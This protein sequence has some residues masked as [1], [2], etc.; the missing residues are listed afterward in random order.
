MNGSPHRFQENAIPWSRG[1]SG[2]HNVDVGRHTPPDYLVLD[3]FMS[4]FDG[5]YSDPAIP[6]TDQ[7][8][9]LAA[10]HQRL[11][12]ILPFGD[13]NGKGTS[14]RVIIRRALDEGLVSSSSEKGPLRIAFPNKVVESYLPQLFT[15]LPV[16]GD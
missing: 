11:A 2:D 1:N 14:S 3:D 13:G 4:R 8:I 16:D 9:A 7:L 10:A 15:D 6:A 5:F 12:W